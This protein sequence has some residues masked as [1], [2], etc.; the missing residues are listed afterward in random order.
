MFVFVGMYCVVAR[1]RLVFTVPLLS[2]GNA[3]LHTSLCAFVLDDI[4]E[5][6]LVH[7]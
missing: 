4:A 7:D 2:R 1:S 6:L 3:G 5:P